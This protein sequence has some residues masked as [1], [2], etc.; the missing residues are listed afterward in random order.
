M[1]YKKKCTDGSGISAKL[2]IS[3][4]VAS[5]SCLIVAC[6][7][8]LRA[9]RRGYDDCTSTQ[10]N[11]DFDVTKSIAQNRADWVSYFCGTSG[12]LLGLYIL[13]SVILYALKLGE[14]K[15]R[16]ID[17]DIPPYW[18][19]NAR[20]AV[21]LCVFYGNVS[22]LTMSIFVPFDYLYSTMQCDSD[23]K[24]DM[25]GAIISLIISI[26]FLVVGMAWGFHWTL[27]SVT[28]FV[29]KYVDE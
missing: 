21:L 9:S 7:L 6:C 10:S 26:V 25:K 15:G 13:T 27:A 4:F 28:R 3:S 24:S 11:N 8:A 23:V 5:C 2:S 12:I 14:K 16:I 1:E 29:L 19:K 17:V 18:A 22:A 20:V